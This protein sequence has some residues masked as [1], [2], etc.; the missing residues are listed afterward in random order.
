MIMHATLITKNACLHIVEVILFALLEG[1]IVT[2]LLE[3]LRLQIVTWVIFVADGKW[4]DIEFLQRTAHSQ[5][6]QYRLLGTVV[7]VLCPTLPLGNP[8]V[9]LLLCDGI[10]DVT[11][12]QLTAFHHLMGSETTT[13][14]KGFVHAHQSL[15][16]GIDEQVVTNTYLH[17]CRIAIFMEQYVEEGRV[18]HDVTMVRDEGVSGLRVER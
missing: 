13:H 15:N 5:H 12:H 9:L 17:C 1:G 3:L 10:V 16:P 6:F 11:T 7:R 14:R 2:F 8:D 18:E 4:H